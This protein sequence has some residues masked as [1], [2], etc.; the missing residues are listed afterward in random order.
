MSAVEVIVSGVLYDKLSRTARP[1]VLI[2]EA[3][4]QN[5][6]IGGGPIIPSEPPLGIWGP[7]DPRP[8]WGLPGDQPRPE[9]P[10]FYPPGIWGP[11]DPRPTPPIHIPPMPTEP[12]EDPGMVKPPPADGGWGWHPEYGWGYFPGPNNSGPKGAGE[13]KKGLFSK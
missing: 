6:G 13:G 12:P 2:G 11:N 3:S 10:I 5:V 4:L 9:H 1:V 7:T 8:G